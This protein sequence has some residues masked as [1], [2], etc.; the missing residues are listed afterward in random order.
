MANPSLE[1][2]NK[3]LAK[4]YKQLGKLENT[5]PF[6]DVGEATKELTIYSI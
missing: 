3:E 1:E 4:L 2:I 5:Q 6:K